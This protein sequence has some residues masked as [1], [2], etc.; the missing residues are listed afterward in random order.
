MSKPK[1]NIGLEILHGLQ[2][3]K[4]SKYARKAVLPAVT[5]GKPQ[6]QNTQ[7]R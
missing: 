5:R 3:I 7:A 1:R 2:E 4:R 6:K